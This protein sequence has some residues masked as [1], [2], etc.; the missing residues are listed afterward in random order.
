MLLPRTPC[1]PTPRP[2]YKGL[3][4]QYD[5]TR[6][7]LPAI[8]TPFSWGEKYEL[9][10]QSGVVLERR[11]IA[12]QTYIWA[13][14]NAYITTDR[15][16]LRTP[17]FITRLDSAQ[18][19]FG[20]SK[21]DTS[22]PETSACIHVSTTI[23]DAITTNQLSYEGDL[24][25]VIDFRAMIQGA[26]KLYQ[27]DPSSMMARYT[28]IRGCFTTPQYT[29]PLDIDVAMRGKAANDYIDGRM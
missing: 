29:A 19:I 7:E 17:V 28:S 11:K 6:T 18:V 20:S 2:F 14:A 22:H 4:M 1:E 12:G 13:L 15:M 3:P 10:R 26:A 9:D 16:I 5:P 8:P 25:P 23:L 21:P 27:V 24:D